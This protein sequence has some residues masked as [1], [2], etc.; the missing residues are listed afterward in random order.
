MVQVKSYCM[1]GLWSIIRWLPGP[2]GVPELAAKSV[3]SPLLRAEQQIFKHRAALVQLGSLLL[4]A[5]VER[6][7][8]CRTS[9]S[10]YGETKFRIR[11]EGPLP[12]IHVEM[13][14]PQHRSLSDISLSPATATRASTANPTGLSD[15][16]LIARYSFSMSDS[17]VTLGFKLLAAA[18]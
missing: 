10:S 11:S 3:A 4:L 8:C 9:A 12:A 15:I 17:S 5:A 6:V 18:L 2:V 13:Y 16:S 1:I 7:A 14:M